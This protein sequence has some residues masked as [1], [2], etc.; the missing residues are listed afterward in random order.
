MRSPTFAAN[1]G[2]SGEVVFPTFC[3]R[4][5][6]SRGYVFERMFAS[7]PFQQISSR[8][9]YTSSALRLV[10]DVTLPDTPSLK[11]RGYS[12]RESIDSSPGAPGKGIDMASENQRPESKKSSAF[13]K[14]SPAVSIIAGSQAN[15]ECS[16]VYTSLFGAKRLLNTALF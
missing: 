1:R 7:N 12:R 4:P 6:S 5:L 10:A 16:V 2:L 9:R 11:W 15:I 14:L 13:R 8:R 3:P